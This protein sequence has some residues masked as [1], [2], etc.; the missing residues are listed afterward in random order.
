MPRSASS[1]VRMPGS[2][3]LPRGAWPPAGVGGGVDVFAGQVG[4][5]GDQREHDDVGVRCA[6][7]R[8]EPDVAVQPD[9]VAGR[10]GLALPGLHVEFE[11]PV[12]HRESARAD[13]LDLFGPAAPGS[14]GGPLLG[15]VAQFVR[16]HQVSPGAAPRGVVDVRAVGEGIRPEGHVGPSGRLP[17]VHP[18]VAEVRVEPALHASPDGIGQDRAGAQPGQFR[19]QGVPVGVCDANRQR[20]AARGRGAGHHRVGVLF[21]LV[22]VL[23][24]QALALQQPDHR[25]VPG[26]A[27]QIQ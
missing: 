6:D 2:P 27:L 21:V 5:L 23:A 18:H 8:E 11:E 19:L 25:P 3:S 15:D 17:G 13:P 1:W 7:L 4:E 14:L 24:Q 10:T 26:G 20:R 12:G 22:A 9:V 16:R